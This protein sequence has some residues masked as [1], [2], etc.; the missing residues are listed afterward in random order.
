MKT[1]LI[2]VVISW[3]VLLPGIRYAA[4]QQWS[5]Q[6]PANA[7]SDDVREGEH[8]ASTDER[9][10]QD[11]KASDGTRDHRF[12]SDR[13]GASIITPSMPRQLPNP[14]WRSMSRNAH[15]GPIRGGSVQSETAN[16]APPVRPPTVVRPLSP[17]L[18][19]VRH[20]SANPAVIGGSAN[21]D[22]RNT[23]ALNGTRMPRKP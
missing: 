12:G 15:G 10:P 5:S 8:A 17:S 20:H 11:G 13:R 1:G 21:S 9:S 14:P 16:P 4:S 3:V 22:A 23:G 2:F 7:S 18:E 19:N 6:G